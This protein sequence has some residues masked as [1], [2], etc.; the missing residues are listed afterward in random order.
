LRTIGD[1]VRIEGVSRDQDLCQFAFCNVLLP[2]LNIAFFVLHTTRML[3]NDFG[4]AWARTRHWNL[5]TLLATTFSWGV[6]GI[7]KGLW[8]LPNTAGSVQG[9]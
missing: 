4:W 3:F 1:C 9:P 6:M 7:W 5:V 8:L 2:A